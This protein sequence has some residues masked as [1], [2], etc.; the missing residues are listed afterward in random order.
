MASFGIYDGT[1][2]EPEDVRLA[3]E[4]REAVEKELA[5][6]A[7]AASQKFRDTNPFSDNVTT[8]TDSGSGP[9][10][11]DPFNVVGTRVD[12]SGGTIG[13]A[14][15]TPTNYG[16]FNAGAGSGSAAPVSTLPVQTMSPVYVPARYGNPLLDR[17]QDEMLAAINAARKA[18]NQGPIT[19]IEARN[20]K[21]DVILADHVLKNQGSEFDREQY[22]KERA[23][24]LAGR[25]KA[26]ELRRLRELNPLNPVI[27]IFKSASTGAWEVIKDPAQGISNV[28][29]NIGEIFNPDSKS[30]TNA[31]SLPVD[32]VTG[33]VL[34]AAQLANAN[35]V[36]RATTALNKAKAAAATGRRNGV[37]EE[38]QADLDD[39]VEGYQT[40]L[41]TARGKTASQGGATGV[42][43]GVGA[44]AAAGGGGG[45]GGAGAAAGATQ[46]G[47]TSVLTGQT[48]PAATG[49]GSIP[50]VGP[51]DVRTPAQIQ[52]DAAAAAAAAAQTTPTSVVA[53]TDGVAAAQAAA[54]KADQ[55]AAWG[56]VGAAQATARADAGS[57][58]TVTYPTDDD[59]RRQGRVLNTAR[60][61][62]VDKVAPTPVVAPPDWSK[63][64]AAQA[65]ARAD[66]GS[67]T[68]VI[69]PTP[70]DCRRQGRVLNAAGTACVDKVLTQQDCTSQ[71][72]VLNDQGTACVAGGG[73]SGGNPCSGGKV[74]NDK[75][76]CVCP[77]GYSDDGRGTC[78]VVP[79]PSTCPVG[80]EK[81]NGVCVVKCGS[82]QERNPQGVC[83]VVPGPSTCPAGQEKVNGACVVKCG[84]GQERNTQGVC[85]VKPG[86]GSGSGSG[87]T[88]PIIPIIPSNPFTMAT[89]TPAQRDLDTELFKTT[90]ALN[91]RRE[92]LRKV[93]GDAL[94]DY[95]DADIAAFD[96]VSGAMRDTNATNTEAAS[97]QTIAANKALRDANLADVN[98]LGGDALL[99]RQTLNSQLYGNINQYSKE[100]S[101][102]LGR[103][104][105]ALRLAE[106][107]QLSPEDIRNSQ[108]AARAAWSS[109]GMLN[110]RGA[111]G[112]EILNLDSL[113][114]KRE[115]EARAKVQ[116]SYGNLQ[117]ATT[118]EQANV[119]DPQAAILGGQYGMQTQNYGTNAALYGQSAEQTRGSQ[120]YVRKVYNPMGEYPNNIYDFNANATTA[121]SISK[122]NNEASVEA[123]RQAGMYGLTSAAIKN[124]G[125]IWDGFKWVWDKIV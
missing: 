39:E 71:G 112:A 37:S 11:L 44:G 103:D 26:E 29:T 104:M 63:V 8:G 76:V 64:D 49:V 56:R 33:A 65:A 78:V 36:T 70:D 41:D 53:P 17:I 5:E 50:A 23:A 13:S 62:C 3:R 88:T 83:V 40:I 125:A 87:G 51:F 54:Q 102:A 58:T 72:L 116:Q 28:A 86:P 94:N 99:N 110:S 121:A 59:C 69:Y 79:G 55:D 68:T 82:G 60:T 120:D 6:A 35:D 80:Q 118:M 20:N 100:A 108:Q 61:A 24:E 123:A 77:S 48:V 21:L 107:K 15:I 73:G 117:Q 19:E 95:T 89:I 98:R 66:A 84:S 22:E 42:A 96:K 81:V 90:R 45:G 38:E 9:F 4:A 30:K 16:P 7:A 2:D 32:L 10:K 119:F 101:S 52:A 113:A 109:R 97:A 115:A 31:V 27:D 106:A 124:A 57:K 111:V 85:V 1:D 46:G 91:N 67:K 122:A 93:Y 105:D 18:R 114:R 25:E 12:N 75:G 47:N 43:V 92:D 74:K 34:T 14:I